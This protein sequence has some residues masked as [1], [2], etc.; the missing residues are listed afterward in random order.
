M[1]KCEDQYIKTPGFIFSQGLPHPACYNFLSP[2]LM[3]EIHGF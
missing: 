3:Q 2:T 1:L